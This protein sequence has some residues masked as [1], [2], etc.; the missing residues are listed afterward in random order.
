MTS[1]RSLINVSKVLNN[2]AHN[3]DEKWEAPEF[4][5]LRSFI[6]KNHGT[7]IDKLNQL[8]VTELYLTVTNKTRILKILRRLRRFCLLM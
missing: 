1:L 7:L 3:I 5:K 2:L 8:V 6:N 4:E